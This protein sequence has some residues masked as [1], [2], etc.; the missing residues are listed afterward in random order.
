MVEQKDLVELAT[1]SVAGRQHF[2]WLSKYP[3]LYLSNTPTFILGV[4]DRGTFAHIE[5]F[6]ADDTSNDEIKRARQEMQP[7]LNKLT[8]TLGAIR[9]KVLELT[10]EDASGDRSGRLLALMCQG[11]KLALYERT[12]GSKLPDN[13]LELFD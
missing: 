6:A 12:D 4:H 13:L 11:G 7:G 10:D 9:D 1:R 5:K 2:E 3:Q 8:V